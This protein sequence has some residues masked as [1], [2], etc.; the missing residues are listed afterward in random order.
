MVNKSDEPHFIENSKA[1]SKVL[2]KPVKI[3]VK[4][5]W[6]GVGMGQSKCRLWLYL[7][8]LNES[9][10]KLDTIFEQDIFGVYD[11]EIPQ[12]IKIFN[13]K[14]DIVRKSQYK[15]TLKVLGTS[16]DGRGHKLTIKSFECEI[17]SEFF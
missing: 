13:E 8:R 3:T 15:D 6:I 4:A 14:S 17:F 5:D 7:M 9:T 1:Q 12:K 16:G 2:F 10:G 11:P